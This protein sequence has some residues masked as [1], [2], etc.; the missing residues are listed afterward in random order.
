MTFNWS[1]CFQYKVLSIV[2]LAPNG[3]Y[4]LVKLVHILLWLLEQQTIGSKLCNPLNSCSLVALSCRGESEVWTYL[5]DDD[6]NCPFCLLCTRLGTDEQLHESSHCDSLLQLELYDQPN[7][8]TGLYD[9]RMQTAYAV[10]VA[11]MHIWKHYV[12]VFVSC[13][14]FGT[15]W[16]VCV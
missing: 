9:Y 12:S 13:L 3:I 16:E 15:L 4:F 6:T 2:H 10:Q 11:T 5:S 14:E 7:I 8:Q 1:N